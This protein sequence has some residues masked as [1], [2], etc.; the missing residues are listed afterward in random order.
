MNSEVRKRLRTYRFMN[1]EM[2]QEELGRKLGLSRQAISDIERGE[3][4]PSLRRAYQ[5]ARLLNT[6]IEEL[7][8]PAAEKQT[9]AS[10]DER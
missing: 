1:G 9:K 6:T 10:G 2:T 7:F 5:I 3:S 8:F 4:V